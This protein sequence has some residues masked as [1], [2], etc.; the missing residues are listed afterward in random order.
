MVVIFKVFSDADDVY[1]MLQYYKQRMRAS[2]SFP[3]VSDVLDCGCNS[4]EPK[5]TSVLK[6]LKFCLILLLLKD[7]NL[8]NM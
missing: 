7:C 8:L 6:I 1:R 4:I 2:L 3:K 5:L